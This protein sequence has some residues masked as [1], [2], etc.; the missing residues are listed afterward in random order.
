MKKG[1]SSSVSDTLRNLLEKVGYFEEEK[2]EVKSLGSVPKAKRDFLMR[3]KSATTSSKDT[4]I[5]YADAIDWLRENRGIVVEIVPCLSQDGE[6]MYCG[7][8][9][10]IIMRTTKHH[11]PSSE[12][13]DA[14]ETVLVTCLNIV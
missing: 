13:M 4:N 1:L 14:L 11:L 9:T 2:R 8:S 3:R 7:K 5:T 6:F 10:D 12:Y